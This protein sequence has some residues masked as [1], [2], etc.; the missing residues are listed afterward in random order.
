M[1]VFIFSFIWTVCYF[2]VKMYA[3]IYYILYYNICKLSRQGIL[4]NDSDI[5]AQQIKFLTMFIRA[6]MQF[7]VNVNLHSSADLFSANLTDI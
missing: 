1:Y 5:T 7:A 3:G 6:I 4:G 2:T